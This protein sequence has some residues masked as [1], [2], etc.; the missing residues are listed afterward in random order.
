M[1]FKAIFDYFWPLSEFFKGFFCCWSFKK[2]D[3]QFNVL[4][5]FFNSKVLYLLSQVKITLNMNIFLFFKDIFVFLQPCIF[6]GVFYYFGHHGCPASQ[7]FHPRLS[8]N[9]FNQ[10]IILIKKKF[11]FGRFEVWFGPQQASWHLK[12]LFGQ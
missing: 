11:R 12:S 4:L 5:F 7:I 2:W 10:A 6:W 1:F 9:Y 3:L 8:F